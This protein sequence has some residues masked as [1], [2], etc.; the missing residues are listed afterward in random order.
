MTMTQT[1]RPG[2]QAGDATRQGLYQTTEQHDIS[3]CERGLSPIQGAICRCGGTLFGKQRGN[4]SAFFA[5][6]L[7]ADPHS[8]HC[9]GSWLMAADNTPGTPS[10]CTSGPHPAN[11]ELRSKAL[12]G[13]LNYATHEPGP[14]GRC[15]YDTIE[16]LQEDIGHPLTAELAMDL[17]SALL[18]IGVEPDYETWCIDVRGVFEELAIAERRLRIQREVL[19]SEDTGV[20]AVI[21]I[22]EMNPD[23]VV[24]F[25]LTEADSEKN[26]FCE[27][28]FANSGYTSLPH[29]EVL[30]HEALAYG[31][32]CGECGQLLVALAKP[33]RKAA[34]RE[35]DG[36]SEQATA[37][38]SP[39][40]E[41]SPGDTL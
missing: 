26:T 32:L 10:F 22:D 5:Q 13:L 8:F 27:E 41:H 34:T 30:T 7:P 4:G 37:A 17:Y 33:G 31:L 23:L 39:L 2:T 29:R 15:V 1:Q 24:G 9:G 19:A 36:T 21:T 28:D 16:D 14:M 18:S 35:R 20:R 25:I 12:L 3:R 38:S 6:L 40:H 11:G